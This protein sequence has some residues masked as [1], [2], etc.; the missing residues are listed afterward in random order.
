MTTTDT[1]A[2]P[3]IRRAAHRRDARPL[4]R[5]GRRLRPREP[6]LR[7]GLRRAARVGL[8]AWR[9]ARPSSAAG[10]GL[11]EYSGSSAASPT[12]PRPPRSPSTCTSTG[13]AS[14]PTCCATATTRA[15]G[16]SRRRPPARCSP[17]LHGEAGND[18]PLLLSSRLGR[19]GR[20]RLGD[21]RPQDL[22]QPDA[23]V[24]LRRL[25]RHGH[26]RPGRPRRSSTASCPATPGLPDRRHVGHA[27]HAGDPEPGHGARHG[28]RARRAGGPRVPGRASPAPARSTSRSSPGRCSAS[29]RS[30]SARRSGRSTSPLERMPQRTSIALT[31]SM[32]HHPEVQHHVAEMRM[33]YDAAEALLE[34]TAPTGRPASTTR[35]GRCAWSPRQ[36]S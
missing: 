10:L 28:V 22:R 30:T 31:R 16:S 18:I 27:R 17:P 34:R 21:Q 29:P 3:S 5:A 26:V 15:D 7:R 11:D 1:H 14:P 23:G 19:A 32:A 24:D 8:P 13:P 33:A 25:P 6:L 9:G 12:S 2:R 35:T 36:Y 20:R 4:R